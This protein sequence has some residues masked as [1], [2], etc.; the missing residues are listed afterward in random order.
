MRRCANDSGTISGRGRG[1]SA[2]RAGPD[3]SS[4][5]AMPA[6]VGKSKITRIRSSTPSSARTLL[7]KR[8]AISE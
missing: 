1:P 6:G 4:R 2:G 7:A 5:A 8:A 3:A